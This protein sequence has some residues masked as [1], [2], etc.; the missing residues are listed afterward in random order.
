MGILGD[1]HSR[2]P[3]RAGMPREELKSKLNLPTREFNAALVHAAGQERVAE[4]GAGIRL[5]EHQVRFTVEQQRRVDELLA[6]FAD[7]PYS[8]P[9][10]AECEAAIGAELLSVLVD[11]GRLVRAGDSVLFLAETY[12]EMVERVVAHIEEEG[13]ITVAQV[14]D[15]FHASR[16]YAL[17]LMEHLD[18]RRITRRV[19]DERVLR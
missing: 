1:Y 7:S 17:A 14:R 13:S 11:G 15:I 18:D 8:T 19:G 10:V 6:R 4:E 16:K 3:M 12:E 5:P 9:S 2:Y